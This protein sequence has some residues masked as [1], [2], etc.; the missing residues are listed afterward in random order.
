M[1]VMVTSR[2]ELLLELARIDPV[3]PE[4]GGEE[5]AELVGGAQRMGRLAK[6]A[7]EPLA[8]EDPAVDLAVADVETE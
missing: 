2:G 1:M 5:D 8:V 4:D 6:L 3:L 7:A